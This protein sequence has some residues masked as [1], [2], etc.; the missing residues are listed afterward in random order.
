MVSGEV[1]ADQFRRAAVQ[2]AA[3]RTRGSR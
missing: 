2:G 1:I 3:K